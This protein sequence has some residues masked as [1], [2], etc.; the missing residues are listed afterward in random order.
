MQI[1][2][3]AGVAASWW[4]SLSLL[5]FKKSSPLSET[6]GEDDGAPK[7]E[8]EDDVEVPRGGVRA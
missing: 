8:G 1:R 7:E 6:G 4:R 2:L 3:V 5:F